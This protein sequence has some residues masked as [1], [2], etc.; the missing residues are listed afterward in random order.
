[1]KGFD[2]KNNKVVKKP[3]NIILIYCIGY[4]ASNGVKLLYIVSK[5]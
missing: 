5:E 4:E 2:P 3:Y 1:M